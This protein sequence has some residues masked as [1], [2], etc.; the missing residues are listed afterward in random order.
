MKRSIQILIEHLLCAHL[1]LILEILKQICLRLNKIIISAIILWTLKIKK[2]F[3]HSILNTLLQGRILFFLVRNKAAT[4]VKYHS[5]HLI[6][7]GQ[8]KTWVLRVLSLGNHNVDNHCKEP[9]LRL[10]WALINQ[11]ENWKWRLLLV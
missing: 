10:W 1:I 4:P 11:M 8:L 7:I 6:K 2:K 3:H 5:N 9:N